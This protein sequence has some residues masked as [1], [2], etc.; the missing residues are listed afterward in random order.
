MLPLLSFLIASLSSTSP[1]SAPTPGTVHTFGAGHSSWLLDGK[2]FQVLSGE[3]H[4]ARIPREYWTDRL[5]KAKAMGLNT[6]CLYV[7]W[8]LIEPELGKFDFSG[9]ND[10]AA[11]I[12]E[13]GKQGLFVT[14]RA[15][16]YVCAEWEWGG[17]PYWLANIP[18]LVVRQ[19]NP[20]FLKVAGEY[21]DALGKHL[22][23]LSVKNGGPLILAQV[24]NEYGSFGNDHAYMAAIRKAYEHAGFDCQFFTAD[25]PGQDMLGGGTF[26]D[27]P[28]AINFGGG[29]E[30]SFKE[31]SKFRL[32][33][34]QMNGEFW[35]GWFDH[36]YDGHNTTS[37]KDQAADLEWMVSRGIS[38][39]LYM[40][41]GGTSFGWMNGANSGG[42][43]FE[44]DTT[45]YDYDAPVAEDGSLTPKYEAF[46]QV[47]ARHL[48][49]GQTL[50]NPPKPLPKITIPRFELN[51]QTALFTH[52]PEPFTDDKAPS[53]EEIHQ[54]YGFVLYRTRVKEAYEGPLELKRLQ[55][56]ALIYVEYKLVGHL[57]RQKGEHTLEV[58]IPAGGILDILVENQGRINFSEAIL[59]EHKGIEAAILGSHTV[60]DWQIYPLP[61]NNLDTFTYS[62]NAAG[63]D[64]P[65]LF[66]GSFNLKSLGDT[67]LDM[68]GW[69]KGNVWVNGHNLGRY[70]HVGPQQALYLP[71]PWL[72]RGKNEVVVLDLEP[73]GMHSV[74][75]IL[76]PVFANP[77]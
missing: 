75:G 69:N 77:K 64:G 54:P 39:N 50:P 5:R 58:K 37:V 21:L 20:Q 12:K 30:G 40:F 61:L 56:R 45:S 19:N 23:G 47:Y 2:P 32:G 31:L 16:P 67:Y 22:A 29:P 6:V 33:G 18:G 72:K 15:G 1:A 73:S 3:M 46:R 43:G 57:E 35:C 74:Q 51:E 14:L 8:N 27:L 17:Y 63:G 26:P 55:D 76:S 65:I 53:F 10:I 7:F 44:P 28:A 36:W 9:Q 11:F 62:K 70:W 60:N 59:N 34:P 4:P 13:A 48:A 66:K 71:A 38:V 52:L 24:E 42:K 49:P 25:G 68:R 41:H